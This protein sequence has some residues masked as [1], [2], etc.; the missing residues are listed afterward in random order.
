MKFE[1]RAVQTPNRTKKICLEEYIDS[2]YVDY[3]KISQRVPNIL[4]SK[5]KTFFQG[6]IQAI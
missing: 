2:K 5:G 4:S 1:Q 3:K 6:E